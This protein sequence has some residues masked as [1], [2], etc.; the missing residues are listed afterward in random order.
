MR[1]NITQWF[2]TSSLVLLTACASRRGHTITSLPSTPPDPGP[3]HI[4]LV[5]AEGKGDAVSGYVEKGRHFL[6]GKGLHLGADVQVDV[7]VLMRNETNSVVIGYRIPES[8]N[9]PCVHF[10][11]DGVPVYVEDAHFI[12]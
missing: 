3:H 1:R 11:L 9:I 2:V 10:D 6:Q 8:T 5:A 12:P 7:W 4:F